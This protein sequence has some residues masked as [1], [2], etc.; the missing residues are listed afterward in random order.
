[1]SYLV[2][3]T[4]DDFIKIKND[5]EYYLVEKFNVDSHLKPI[6]DGVIDAIMNGQTKYRDT[7]KYS[8]LVLNENFVAFFT[9]YKE[10]LEKL[11]PDC[12]VSYDSY[13]GIDENI[14]EYVFTVDWS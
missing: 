12:T 13:K 9:K 5:S 11:F 3:L 2:P 14:T 8:I 4:K 7:R 10:R 1:M 6:Y